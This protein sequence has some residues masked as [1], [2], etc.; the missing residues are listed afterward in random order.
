[1][2]IYWHPVV[3][4][5]AVTLFPLSVFF[6][7][8]AII[9]KQTK[10]RLA[11]WS[12]LVLS[13]IAILAAVATGLLAKSRLHFSIK[14]ETTL[15]LHQTLAFISITLV[16]FLLFWRIKSRESL[17]QPGSW[18]YIFLA[19]VCVT[20]ILLG[21]FYGGKLVHYH[22]VGIPGQRSIEQSVL[23]PIKGI[24]ALPENDILFQVA[25]SV[26]NKSIE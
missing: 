26:H 11:A 20:L 17:P 13:G 1:M 3:V 18:L 23:P 6:D 8:A 9:L 15:D 21:G 12:T 4:H 14:A 2:E 10:F 24:H 7:L 5:F 25:D 16:F 19:M 22:G